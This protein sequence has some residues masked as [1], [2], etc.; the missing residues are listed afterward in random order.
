MSEKQLIKQV[1]FFLG[2]VNVKISLFIW[3]VLLFNATL[4]S[5]SGS[6]HWFNVITMCKQD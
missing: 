1:F 5:R 6:V 3:L 2:A 4:G